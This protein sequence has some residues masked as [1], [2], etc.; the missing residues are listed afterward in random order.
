MVN[1]CT[2][3]QV[4]AVYTCVRILAKSIVG[5]TISVYHYKDKGKEMMTDHPLY[6]LL[7]DEPAPEMTIFIFRETL[8]GICFYTAMPMEA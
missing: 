5:L 7:H 4:T 6:P 1:R 2:A 8:M 3:V